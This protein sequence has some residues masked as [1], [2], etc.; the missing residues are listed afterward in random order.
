MSFTPDEK[1]QKQAS[2]DVGPDRILVTVEQFQAPDASRRGR[3]SFFQFTS[4]PLLS[5]SS[6][7]QVAVPLLNARVAD[8]QLDDADIDDISEQSARGKDFDCWRLP[9]S[10]SRRGQ[11]RLGTGG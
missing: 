9:S 1:R 7:V 3:S 11:V 6:V 8:Q 10:R 5:S 4:S 2:L